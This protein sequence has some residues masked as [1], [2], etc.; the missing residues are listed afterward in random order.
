MTD[1]LIIL[2]LIFFNGFF[3]L[4][5]VALISARKNRIEAMAKEGSRSAAS[6][7]KLMNDPDRFLSTAQVGITIVAILTGLFSG[8]TFAE[9]FGE[10]LLSLGMSE[11]YAQP[12]AQIIILVI[13]TYMSCELGELFPKKLGI[14]RAE[15]MA[16]LTAPLMTFFSRVSMPIVWLLSRNTELIARWFNL[17]PENHN[18]TEEEIKSIIQEGTDS[19][20]VQEVEQDIMERA[21]ALGDQTVEQVM[22]HRSD[23]V[24]LE[25]SMKSSEV[26]KIITEDTYAAYPVVGDDPDEVIGVVTLKGLVAHLWQK[27]FSLRKILHK[28][29]YF[30][31]NMTVYKALEELK[32]NKFNRA[33]VVD[34]FGSVQGIIVLRD[35]MEGLVGQIP[36]EDETLD[37]VENA[38]HNSWSVSG[39][40]QFYDFLAFFD[41]EDL[42]TPDYNTVGGL[43]LD[44]LERIPVAGERLEWKSFE[45]RIVKMDGTRIDTLLVRHTPLPQDDKKGDGEKSNH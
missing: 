36:D 28:P 15:S 27:D 39:Q 34:E 43:I 4:A 38:D 31:E 44:V 16:K 30:P 7:L 23:I 18:V 1:I 25:A 13:V 20:E 22:T 45:F 10:L 5:E 6:A 42:Y 9:K 41:E 19:G 21:L 14:D 12:V 24:F 8:E 40:C 26:Q 2:V 17:N 29:L 33:L 11:N 32:R 3:S 37:I 35:I